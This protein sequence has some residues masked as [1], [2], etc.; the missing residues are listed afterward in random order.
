MATFNIPSFIIFFS[1]F[2]FAFLSPGNTLNAAMGTLSDSG[3]LSMALTLQLVSQTLLLRS[4]T[5]TI[6]APSDAAFVHIG[7]PSLNQ[8]Q[9]HISPVHF[10]TK[11]LKALPYGSTIPTLLPNHSLI[12]TSWPSDSQLSINN[13]KINEPVMYDNNQS[14]IGH[15]IAEF[16]ASSL[17]LSLNLHPVP[18]PSSIAEPNYPIL[19]KRLAYYGRA[20]GL[21]RSRGYTRMATFLNMQLA[22][23][24]NGTKLTIFAPIDREIDEYV[25]NNFSDYSVVF[26]RH[27]VPDWITWRDLVAVDDGKTLQTCLESFNIE[28]KK[29]GDNLE[30]NGLPV[31][32]PDMYNSEWLLVHGL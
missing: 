23:S 7:Q 21:L 28:V 29:S 16:F 9:C 1:L 4:P 24:S 27:V 12:V 8:L 15:G 32:F 20:S 31:I 6:F 26:R 22:G 10:P 14:L 3:H 25:K 2:S 13:V 19:S 11:N 30:V 5:A 17:R 18:S